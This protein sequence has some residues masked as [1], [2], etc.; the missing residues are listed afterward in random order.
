LSVEQIKALMLRLYDEVVN[1]GNL[2][3]IDDLASPDFVDHEALPGLA[4]GRA[5]VKQFFSMLRTA[6]PDLRMHVDDLIA[7]GDKAV[8]RVT[9]TGT[10]Q[11]E[12]AGIAA[13]GKT[14]SVPTIDI[15]RFAEGKLVEHWGVTDTASM[16]A[17]LGALPVT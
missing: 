6:F 13:T 3:M 9:M 2:D 14:V 12:F 17:Q 8:A 1:G 11:G 10:H 7:E 4:A 15:V 16:M 5:G